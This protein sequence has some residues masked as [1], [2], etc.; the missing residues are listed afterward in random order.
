M[1]IAPPFPCGHCGSLE[2][3]SYLCE[4]VAVVR[5]DVYEHHYRPRWVDVVGLRQHHDQ[6]L[7]NDFARLTGTYDDQFAAIAQSIGELTKAQNNLAEAFESL[8]SAAARSSRLWESRTTLGRLKRLWAWVR[9]R[10]NPYS[11]PTKC[12]HGVTGD[13]SDTCPDCRH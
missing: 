12:P 8:G 3:A 10:P 4:K 11:A 6:E 2:H 13:W 7:R 5:P 9:R 1:A